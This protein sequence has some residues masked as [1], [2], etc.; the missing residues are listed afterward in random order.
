MAATGLADLLGFFGGHVAIGDG[1]LH[2]GAHLRALFRETSADLGGLV[3]GDLAAGDALFE[4]RLPL[5]QAGLDV[6]FV[7]RRGHRERQLARPVFLAGKRGAGSEHE[8]ERESGGR[9]DRA[10]GGHEGRLQ[11]VAA[12]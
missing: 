8:G 2:R 7:R 1:L 10:E 11:M 12:G 6:L 9:D 5:L 4:V 3:G